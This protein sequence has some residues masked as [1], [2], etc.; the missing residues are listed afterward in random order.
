[1]KMDALRFSKL[2]VFGLLPFAGIAVDLRGQ[3]RNPALS[4]AAAPQSSAGDAAMESFLPVQISGLSRLASA[5]GYTKENLYELIDGHADYYISA[6]F[7]G[8]AMADY[9]MSGR[10]AKDSV[11]EIY[12]YDMAKP[13][14][15]FS[16]L[17]DE[18]GGKIH[19]TSTE[20]FRNENLQSVSFSSGRYYVRILAYDKDVPVDAVQKQIKLAIGIADEE[21]PEFARLPS[22]GEVIKT[23]FVRESYMGIS[24]LNDVIERQ[25]K[26]AGGNTTVSLCFGTQDDIKKI[27]ES[28][29]KYLRDSKI[30][31]T[32]TEIK[33]ST[34]YKVNDPYEGDWMLIPLGDSLFGLY[35]SFD[36]GI[37]GEIL[38]EQKK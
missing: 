30:N 19:G 35:G 12:I 4:S 31:Y 7:N 37:V 33:G 29:I 22:L 38:G 15:A 34:V 27:T 6:G 28:L 2:L 26:T 5:K 20:V 3:D 13:I 9:G 10:G 36:D 21:F 23:R 25:Y 16:V 1:M 14:Q 18:A 11:L 17:N 8:L 24:G 32:E